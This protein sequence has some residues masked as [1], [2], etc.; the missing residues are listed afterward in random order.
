M[1][2]VIMARQPSGARQGSH[3]QRARSLVCDTLLWQISKLPIVELMLMTAE[4][5]SSGPRQ[6]VRISPHI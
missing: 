6:D 1:L 4:S 2:K 3:G 5:T